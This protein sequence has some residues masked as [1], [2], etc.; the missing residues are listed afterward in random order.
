MHHWSSAHFVNGRIAAAGCDE[1]SEARACDHH[2]RGVLRIPERTLA[3]PR[4]NKAQLVEA[5]QAARNLLHLVL[6][7]QLSLIQALLDF[8]KR[9]E[10][11]SESSLALLL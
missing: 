2:T 4:D 5:A 7:H 1:N 3:I 6:L 8:R 11:E 9:R 10:L